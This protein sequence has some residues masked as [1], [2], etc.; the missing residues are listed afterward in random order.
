MTV[1]EFYDRIGG[2]YD[3]AMAQL[4]KEERIAEYLRMYLADTSFATLKEGMESDNMERAF[5]G[6]HTLKGVCANLAFLKLRDA[7][8]E[9][10]EALHGGKDIPHAKEL[11]PTVEIL[12]LALVE[13]INEYLAG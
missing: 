8:S 5:L 10:T 4:R 6:A 13:A 7:S 3:E 2:G 1:K 9:L 12:H 11:Y